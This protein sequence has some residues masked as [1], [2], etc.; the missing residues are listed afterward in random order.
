[1]AD[2]KGRILDAAEALFAEQGYGATSL[3]SIITAAGVNLAAVHY[4]FGSKDGLLEAVILRR[5]EPVNRERLAML[6]E[7]EATGVPTVE[8][9]LAAFIEPTLAIRD[10]PAKGGMTF[11]KLMG[12]LHLE[13]NLLPEIIGKNFAELI[14]H[15]QNALRAALPH[16]GDRELL[17]RIHF[18][19]GAMAHALAGADRLPL[20]HVWSGD[21]RGVLERLIT[22]LSAGFRAPASEA[23]HAN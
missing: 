13:T 10:D 5:V 21:R 16:L 19:I 11:F 17:W 4:H 7:F 8:Q 6:E 18:A 1:M 20:V 2:T 3:R 14:A 15:F 9:V 22:F 12:R 23:R